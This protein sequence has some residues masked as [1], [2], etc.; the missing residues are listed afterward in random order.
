[1]QAIGSHAGEKGIFKDGGLQFFRVLKVCFSD[2]SASLRQWLSDSGNQHPG[3]VPS[4]TIPLYKS[5]W[6]IPLYQCRLFYCDGTIFFWTIPLYQCRLFYCDGTI[7]FWTIP[8]YQCRLFYCV[9]TIFFVSFH[10][11]RSSH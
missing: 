8:L 9:G 3:R 6:T 4:Q 5:S 7:F 2:F 10:C 11:V 1:M